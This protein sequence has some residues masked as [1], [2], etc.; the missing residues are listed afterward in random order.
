MRMDSGKRKWLMFGLQII[1]FLV[2][3]IVYFIKTV[4]PEIKS[5]VGSSDRLLNAE[6]Y[7]NMYEIEINDSVDFTLLLSDTYQIYHIM[8]L[9]E[10]SKVLYN[11]NI[12][13]LNNNEEKINSIVKILIENDLL[14]SDSY[15]KIVRYD[16]VYYSHF[17]N[18]INST[19]SKYGIGNIYVE[20]TSTIS[21][22]A[23]RL[24]IYGTDDKDKLRYIDY[25]SKTLVNHN[26]N[27]LNKE[28]V[29]LNDATSFSLSKS[30]YRRIEDYVSTNN[31]INKDRDDDK[32]LIQL[33]PADVNDRY[34]PDENSWYY[35]ENS[36]I[37]AY[38]EFKST[39][40]IYSFCYNGSI[41]EVKNGVC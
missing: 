16:D 41:D 12:E 28:N 3:V 31:I 22:L 35:V 13:L 37:Y 5:S 38:I 2:I 18:I 19:F 15:I 1:L 39:S 30:V 27:S 33:I 14:K 32:F 29:V 6:K 17:I 26:K 40:K 36:H 9:N 24:N 21:D 4:Y 7:L 8:F 23:N 34:Y 25:Y 20:E 10:N 11:K